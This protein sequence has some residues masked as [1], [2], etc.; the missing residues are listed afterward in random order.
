MVKEKGKIH[1]TIGKQ[2]LYMT[3][4]DLL[5][6]TKLVLLQLGTSG[7]LT[8]TSV[9][10]KVVAETLKRTELECEYIFWNFKLHH[11]R[12]SL[13]LIVFEFDPTE[14][15]PSSRQHE[16]EFEKFK[17]DIILRIRIFLEYLE[18]VEKSPVFCST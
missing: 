8:K 14:I 6:L 10:W 5:K 16:A 4:I 12:P 15:V 9:N 17:N 11:F 7:F 3:V 2:C 13:G 1:F 18:K